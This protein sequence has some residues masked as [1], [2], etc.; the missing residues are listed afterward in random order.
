MAAQFSQTMRALNG[1]R[2]RRAMAIWLFAGTLLAGWATWFVGG[3]V[4]VFEE[5]GRARL[6][7]AQAPH[8][9][10]S[11]V[12]G[13]IEA[14]RLIVGATVE[15]GDVLVELDTTRERLRLGEEQSRLAAAAAKAQH[16]RREIEAREKSMEEE[17]K[18]AEVAAEIARLRGEETQAALELAQSTRSRIE[19]MAD[20]GRTPRIE[21]PKVAAEV[22]KL[23]AERGAWR[24]EVQRLGRDAGVRKHQ[25]RAEIEDRRH[26]LAAVEGEHA[27]S[28]STIA[29]MEAEIARRQIRA[30]VA[31]R[32][33]EVVTLRP[34]AYVAEGQRLAT[35]VPSG[36][37]IVV[38]SF[39]PQA[40]MGRIRS[41]Q[42]ARMRLDGF[43]WAQY[44]TITATV[45]HV[46]GEI[47]DG[48]ARV[49][50]RLDAVPDTGIELQHGLPGA[51]EV[52]IERTSPALLVLH[53]AGLLLAEAHAQPLD[54]AGAAR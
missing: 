4:T 16:L 3:S 14:L 2:P 1:D 39:V 8:G 13:Q 6:E 32:V 29:L 18:T 31:G 26:E 17:A 48:M 9:V 46:A 45:T 42:R 22:R 25:G 12:A 30:P 37:L 49:Q 15:A 52:E 41:G 34:G 40:A 21:V 33:G 28:L 54:G 35:I 50:L 10:D 51:V 36:E 47:R 27:A 23:T 24:A 5:T 53:A 44:G 20:A 19:Q 43:P 38:A 11:Q 7:A